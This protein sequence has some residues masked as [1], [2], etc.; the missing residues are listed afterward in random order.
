M[1]DV[2]DVLR[3]SFDMLPEDDHR[4]MFLDVALYAPERFS[5]WYNVAPVV[6]GVCEW[7]SIVYEQDMDIVKDKVR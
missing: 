2:D 5:F 1:K 3:T 4:A 7:L 6:E